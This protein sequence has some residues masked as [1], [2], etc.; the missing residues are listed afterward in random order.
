MTIQKKLL[1]LLI[2]TSFALTTIGIVRW[3]AGAPYDTAHKGIETI[4][5]VLQGN[6][7][8]FYR[9]YNGQPPFM[10]W[11]LAPIFI[12]FGISPYSLH[13]VGILSGVLTTILLYV[14]GKELWSA[15]AGLYA[16]LF[17]TTSHW[18][19]LETREGTHNIPL[20][21]MLLFIFW[22]I[23]KIY[24]SKKT[25]QRYIL[26]IAGGVT[27]GLFGYVYS[28]GW[29]FSILFIFVFPALLLISLITSKLSKQRWPLL[30]LTT[31]M[32]LVLLP[33]MQF[34][35]K[36]PGSVTLH[37]DDE[38]RTRNSDYLVQRIIKNTVPVVGAFL[39]IPIG[40]FSNWETN[41]QAN[42]GPFHIPFPVPFVSPGEGILLCIA[43][44]YV[45][46]SLYTK[47]P[48]WMPL[49]LTIVLILAF[50]PNLLTEGAQ[51]HYR[52]T[53]ASMAPLF[54]LLGYSASTIHQKISL[55][56][57]KYKWM[58]TT[59]I[60]AS[61][62]YGPF[63]YFFYIIPSQ[64]FA[65]TYFTKHDKVAPYLFARVAAGQRVTLAGNTAHMKPFQFY[66]LATPQGRQAFHL[67][68]LHTETP[69]PQDIINKTDVLFY[70]SPKCQEASL[71]DFLPSPIILE[72][73]FGI[74]ACIFDRPGNPQALFH[75][76]VPL[77][78]SGSLMKKFLSSQ[79]PLKK[80]PS[81]Q[82]PIF[83]T[84]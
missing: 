17:G 14:V 58:W 74:N 49:L 35:L 24:K 61:V 9:H 47:H 22:C 71:P 27:A 78:S 8:P 70:V 60:V 34:V 37:A 53:A 81:F 42:I 6:I 66:A 63:L 15:R 64:W 39:Y 77:P 41:S 12:V 11:L 48:L 38:I 75:S 43:F 83:G 84:N 50:S 23:I 45:F 68:N 40:P 29:I 16:S 28:A 57:N 19:L 59:F 20:V 2:V 69:F 55:V 25:T 33:F 76:Q 54:L 80:A 26:A 62:L 65:D 1:I 4:E 73:S 51:P 30:I 13:S 79:K 21:P 18:F 31:A 52:R 36:D 3:N 46:K 67:L 5:E 44:F 32:F 56:S 72:D 82:G 7:Q 10:D